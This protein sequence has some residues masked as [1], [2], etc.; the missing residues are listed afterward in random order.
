MALAFTHPLA[1]AAAAVAAPVLAQPA[2]TP[3]VHTNGTDTLVGSCSGVQ[4]YG[5]RTVDG[6][7][8][9]SFAVGTVTWNIGNR[10]MDWVSTTNAHPQLFQNIY[11]AR[12]KQFEHV[13]LGWGKHGFAVGNGT[14]NSSFGTCVTSVTG[15]TTGSKL[16]VNCSDSYGAGT[17]A[18]QSH[19]G[20]RFDC[21][22]MT[23][24]FTFPQTAIIPAVTSGD[25][26]ARRCVG[27]D[28]DFQ[29]PASTGAT[30]YAE[31]FALAPDDASWGN[32][33]NNYST[34][35]LAAL[36]ALSQGSTTVT[37]NFATTPNYRATALEH[38]VAD[39]A[40]VVL[41]RT[42]FH[43]QNVSI[44][45]RFE[46]WDP[47]E[48][49]LVMRPQPWATVTTPAFGRFLTA[50]GSTDNGD[51]TWT[52]DYAVMNVNSHRA[53]ASVR[54]R[55]P[56]GATVS[57]HSAFTPMYHS[58]DR[59]R[60]VPWNYD[61]DDVRLAWTVDP[62]TE[63]RAVTGVG[64]VTFNPNALMFGA[65]HSF[66]FTVNKPPTLGWFHLGFFRAPAD[67]NGYQKSSI[68]ITDAVVPTACPADTGSQGAVAAPDGVLDNNDFVVFIDRFF[69]GELATADV[70]RQGGL[71][72]PDNAL[73][74]ND[75]VVFIDTVF[76][77]CL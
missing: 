39:T 74:N 7:N 29:A 63:Q 47:G 43:E 35:K 16:G 49:T 59:V 60:N 70:G 18:G 48:T 68:A 44:L 40:G 14:F 62:T 15:G 22:P 23:G 4:T 41:T 66:R 50:S 17:N 5:T 56:A 24:A 9:R 76:N 46:S 73:D 8:L 71:P 69:A 77:G 33:R 26:V 53:G 38:F 19:L 13:A 64:T 20:P 6:Q 42:D 30:Y 37:L 65:V 75:F 57:S 52:Y 28:S 11:R 72:G 67:V 1:I 25:N 32:S 34:R 31:S 58:G 12:G 21:N 55:L 51:G 45:D 10:L 54:F 2:E 3:L 61:K 36:P 27:L